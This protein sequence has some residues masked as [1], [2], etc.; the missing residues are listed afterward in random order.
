MIGGQGE[1]SAFPPGVLHGNQRLCHKRNGCVTSGSAHVS[2][3]FVFKLDSFR[4]VSI[5]F[6]FFTESF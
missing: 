4:Y 5:S 6:L 3:L 2:Y 1:D